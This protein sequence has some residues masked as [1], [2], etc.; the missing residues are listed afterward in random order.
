MVTVAVTVVVVLCIWRF[1]WFGLCQFGGTV[2]VVVVVVFAEWSGCL[3]GLVLTLVLGAF[4][5]L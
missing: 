5:D 2:V 4:Y 3:G 1:R